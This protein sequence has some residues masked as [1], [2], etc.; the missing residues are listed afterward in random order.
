MSDDRDVVVDADD[1]KA[2]VEPVRSVV[3]FN[4]A[5]HGILSVSPVIPYFEKEE[6]WYAFRDSVFEDVKPEGGLQAALTDRLATLLWRL[7][8]VVRYEREAVSSNMR[9]VGRDLHLADGYLGKPETGF[10]LR[11]KERMD[12][13]AMARLLP[14]EEELQKILRYEGRLH[15]YVLQIIRQL[16]QLQGGAGGTGAVCCAV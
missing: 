10:T 16:R 4:A 14:N 5:K 3:R 2:P 12:R 11:K 15:R 7:M 13:M 8:R 9:E 1:V 6:D